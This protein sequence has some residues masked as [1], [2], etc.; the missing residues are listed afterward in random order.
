MAWHKADECSRRLAKIP[1]VG[2]IGA[3]LLMMKTRRP[4]CF[5][6]GGSSRPGSADA[7]GSFNGRQGQARRHHKG[8]RRS[9][10]QRVSGWGD[11]RR[12]TSTT[13]WARV[14]LDRRPPQAQTAEVGRRGVGQQM[15]R[16]AWKLMV[17]GNSYAAKSA[18]AALMGAA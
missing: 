3:A 1:G 4:R 8:R 12:P 17:T 13:R 2:P 16:I 9:L 15:A 7:E 11:R 18:P 5:D 14:A 10:A 6:R